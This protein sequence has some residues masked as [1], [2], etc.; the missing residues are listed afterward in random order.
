MRFGVLW[1]LQYINIDLLRKLVYY[2]ICCAVV[3]TIYQYWA[4]QKLVYYAIWCAVVATVYQYW[5]TS[6]ISVL[7]DLVC[8]GGYNIS[9]LGYF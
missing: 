9:I 2:A 4:T 1:W 3:A 7:C 5:S 8:C 6:E